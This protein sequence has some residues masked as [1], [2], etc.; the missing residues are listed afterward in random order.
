MNEATP[1]VDKGCEMKL[2]V[3]SKGSRV[4]MVMYRSCCERRL[5]VVALWVSL[6]RLGTVEACLVKG[7]AWGALT[8]I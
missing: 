7:K 4:P 8:A 2:G 5:A 3:K 1:G 6:D